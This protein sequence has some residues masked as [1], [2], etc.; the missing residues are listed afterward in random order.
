MVAVTS[1]ISL[2]IILFTYSYWL[3]NNNVTK[4]DHKIR[5]GIF[6]IV[7]LLIVTAT[8]FFI[9]PAE[10]GWQILLFDAAIVLTI[11][12]AHYFIKKETS[13]NSKYWINYTWLLVTILFLMGVIPTLKF[14]ETGYNNESTVRA[15][16]KLLDLRNMREQRNA[17]IISFYHNI[18]PSEKRDSIIKERENLGIYTGFDNNTRYLQNKGLI[19][20]SAVSGRNRWDTLYCYVRPFYDKSIVENKYLLMNNPLNRDFIWYQNGNRL[21]LKYNSLT[22]HINQSRI[23]PHYIATTVRKI[24]FVTPFSSVNNSAKTNLL[25]NLFF[26]FLI[27]YIFFRLLKFGLYRIFN[28]YTIQNYI[29]QS[30]G[31]KLQQ[32]I[33]VNRNLFV[34]RQSPA[35]QTKTFLEDFLSVPERKH[36]EWKTSDDVNKTEKVIDDFKK[37][38]SSDA[39]VKITPVILITGFGYD[40][41]NLL[42]L[43]E[44]LSMLKLL[45]WR[46][47]ITLIIFSQVSIDAIRNS[48]RKLLSGNTE[49]GDD[50]RKVLSGYSEV[51]KELDYICTFLLLVTF[52]FVTT[53]LKQMMMIIAKTN[54]WSQATKRGLIGN[55]MFVTTCSS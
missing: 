8:G 51:I 50:S 15:R 7:L 13:D 29:Y 4:R 47:D 41:N 28:H 30:Y 20:Q 14:Y 49:K 19:K 36:I 24:N 40:Y 55:L 11:V 46:D 6:N 18:N 44:K 26:W 3:L 45:L 38:L 54:L 27:M 34:V 23:K 2:T 25:L 53:A 22:E 17:K 5:F 10:K 12:L 43:N 32:M 37:K 52:R 1:I 35:D 21:T 42:L 39:N 48:Y 33:S 31:D 16:H 9:A